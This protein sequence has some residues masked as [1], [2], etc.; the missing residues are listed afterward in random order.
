ME[1]TRF[2]L[3]VDRYELNENL[4][5]SIEV[6]DL[7]EIDDL[8]IDCSIDIEYSQYEET[9]GDDTVMNGTKTTTIDM[10]QSVDVDIKN[11]WIDGEYLINDFTT[12]EIEEMK[13]LIS[14]RIKD[15]ND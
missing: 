13:Q 12:H 14:Q 1:I 9:I 6:D 15:L 8:I 11:I 10:V 2:D 5:K 7:I 3:D 4:T